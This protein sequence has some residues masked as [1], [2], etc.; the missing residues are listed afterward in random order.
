[1]VCQEDSDGEWGSR[2][3]SFDQSG[4]NLSGS[5]A[6]SAEKVV[7]GEWMKVCRGAGK[8]DRAYVHEERRAI[9][10]N[11][12]ALGMADWNSEDPHRTCNNGRQWKIE[13]S[14]VRGEGAVDLR[15]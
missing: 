5:V 15:S 14:S 12:S 8:V 13:M 6:K 1:M 11:L 10:Q 4:M 2:V 3:V 9:D 7:V